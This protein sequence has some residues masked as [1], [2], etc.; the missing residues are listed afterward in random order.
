MSVIGPMARSAA[1]L[2]L[3]LGV[4]AGPDERW[5]GIGY[6]L[7]LPAPRHDR[8]AD[9]RVLVLD[10]HPLCPTA[11]EIKA[12]LGELADRLGKLGCT[13]LR[14]AA[15]MPNLAVTTRTYQEL[16]AAFFSADRTPSERLRDEAAAS[17]LSPENQGLGAAWLR[18]TT[19]SHVA[20]LN[21]SRLREGLRARWNALLATVDVILC[22]AMPTVAFP[23]DHTSS[24]E[25]RRLDVDGTKVLYSNQV[26]WAALATTNGFPATTMPIGRTQDGLPIG[27]Q[28]IG[29]YLQDRTTIAFAGLLEREFGGFARPPGF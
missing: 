8:L 10:T 1:D 26:A 14:Q 5:N 12:A 13:V 28:I 27:A 21:T 22:P 23:H 17:A 9:Y 15:G 3:A 18:G 24:W 11:S 25:E 19:M 29:G 6:R 7:D 20:W 16:L 2:A 4:L